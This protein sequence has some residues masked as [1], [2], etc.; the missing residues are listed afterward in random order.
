MSFSTNM[1]QPVKRR[2]VVWVLSLLLIM[3]GWGQSFPAFAQTLPQAQTE[4]K[5]ALDVFRAAYENRYIWDNKFPGYTAAVELKEKQETYRGQIRIN[6]DLTVEI[7]GFEN[8]KVR[9]TLSNQ[10]QMLIT[11]RRPISFKVAHQQHSFTFGKTNSNGAV[12]IDQHGNGTPSYYE[13]KDGKI[14]Q[15][16]RIMGPVAITVDLLASQDTP[17][18]YLGTEYHATFHYIQTGDEL[19]QLEF[20]DSY[21][22]IG[23]YYIPNHQTIRHLEAGQETTT[24]L[25][26]TDIK[27]QSFS[28]Q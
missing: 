14:V 20:T 22:K 6:P 23:D 27:L 25:N 8:P 26:F 18:G 21:Q 16:N 9:D 15:V 10:M 11:H 17:K 28:L 2:I 4:S 24:E 12:E 19:E 7:T 1:Q 3:A 13:V 5:S